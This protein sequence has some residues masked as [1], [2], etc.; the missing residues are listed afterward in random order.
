MQA[1]IDI[2]KKMRER[3]LISGVNWQQ[4]LK[5]ANQWAQNKD[6]V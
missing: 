3:K 5:S 4:E 6:W 1:P 2:K